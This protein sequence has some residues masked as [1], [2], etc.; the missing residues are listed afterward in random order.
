MLVP[1]VLA[2]EAAVLAPEGPRAVATGG[3]KT[4]A[5]GRAQPVGEERDPQNT[6]PCPGGVE[7]SATP[8]PSIEHISLVEFDLVSAEQLQQLRLEVFPLVMLLLPGD[9]V[10]DASLLR[11]AY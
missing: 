10:L 6:Q 7:E 4:G 8:P 9:V 5:A 1:T 11:L 3:A 2:R